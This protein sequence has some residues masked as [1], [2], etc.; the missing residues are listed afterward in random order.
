MIQSVELNR[1]NFRINENFNQF[2]LDNHKGHNSS[3]SDL[4]KTKKL[5]RQTIGM[6]DQQKTSRTPAFLAKKIQ[7]KCLNLK[8]ERK[9]SE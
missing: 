1:V 2:L 7:T 6:N 8:R 5:L 3:L 9:P 4:K